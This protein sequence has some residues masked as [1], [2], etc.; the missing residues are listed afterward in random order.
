MILI[1]KTYL[2]EH[3][4]LAKWS[5][6][7]WLRNFCQGFLLGISVLPHVFPFRLVLDIVLECPSKGAFPTPISLIKNHVWP[8]ENYHSP[9]QD[10]ILKMMMFLFKMWDMLA[11]WRVF[12]QNYKHISHI[13]HTNQHEKREKELCCFNTV[14]VKTETSIGSKHIHWNHLPYQ[15]QKPHLLLQMFDQIGSHCATLVAES[16]L[17]HADA[18]ED[19]T[20]F[21]ITWEAILEN[22]FGA[23][24]VRVMVVSNLGLNMR[25]PP[26]T[27]L[28]KITIIWN[29]AKKLDLGFRKYIY[30]IYIYIIY[31]YIYST[32]HH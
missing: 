14:L 18:R 5:F 3:V 9:Q 11:P 2:G 6:G 19:T 1:A 32:C 22:R 29:L 20:V 13:S 12:I 26:L 31:I 16:L 17:I 27:I 10:A 30:I 21:G 23:G 15:L 25:S 28:E 7:N 24:F 8:V 4:I